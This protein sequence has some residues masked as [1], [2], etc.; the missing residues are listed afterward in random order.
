MHDWMT[1]WV[2]SSLLL[3]ITL[4]RIEMSRERRMQRRLDLHSRFEPRSTERNC[5]QLCAKNAKAV[6]AAS[7]CRCRKANGIDV[8]NSPSRS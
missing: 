7:R 3:L 2:P 4:S 6:C 8:R 5:A 1:G